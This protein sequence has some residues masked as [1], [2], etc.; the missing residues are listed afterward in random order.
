MKA[1]KNALTK[2]PSSLKTQYK[3]LYNN[4]CDH[5]HNHDFNHPEKTQCK[6]DLNHH[7]NSPGNPPLQTPQQILRFILLYRLNVKIILMA[8][9]FLVAFLGLLAPLLQKMFIDLLTKS[10][11]FTHYDLTHIQS[12]PLWVWLLSSAFCLIL[13]LSCY[14]LLLYFSAQEAIKTQKALSQSL[15]EHLLSLRPLD[16]QNKSTGDFISAYSTDIPSATIL[17]E[18]SLPQGLNILFPLILAPFVLMTFFHVPAGNLIPFLLGF[19]LL[20]MVLAYRQSLFFYKFKHLAANRISLVHEWIQNMKALRILGWIPFFENSIQKARIVETSN[21][22]RMLNNGQTMNAFSSSMTFA[23]TAYIL[24]S[25]SSPSS[26]VNSAVTA[27][28]PG[29]LLAIFWIV[30]VFLTRSF[31]QLPW[32]LTFLFDAWTSIKRLS[33]IFALNPNKTVSSVERKTSSLERKTFFSEKNHNLTLTTEP[34]LKVKGLNLLIKGNPILKN[35]SFQTDP[36][37][38]VGLIGPVGSGK[39][40]LLLSLMGET[41]AT[42]DSYFLG[43]IDML[44][45]ERKQW[46]EFFSFIPQEGFLISASVRD[47][48][49]FEYESNPKKDSQ[50]LEVLPKVQF[51][52]EKEGLSQ[53]LDTVIGERGLNLSGGQKQRLSLA[54]TQLR[55]TPVSLFDDCLSAIDIH[56]EDHIIHHLFEKDQISRL[57]LLVTARYSVLKKV[58]RILFLDEGSLLGFD[59]W[60]QLYSHSPAFYHFINTLHKTKETL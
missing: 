52:L 10:S 50:I 17:V 4:L 12:I 13:S 24:W 20:N 56:T 57:R 25:L 7:F 31:R 3:N 9:A 36:A 15:Y 35:I 2:I 47:N 37:E 33:E 49:H 32:F 6:N 38:F 53:G 39:S 19:V 27:F 46:K 48:L 22:I 40:L 55:Q 59:T 45:I 21:R 58:H 34:F 16:Y 5:S 42:F 30:S 44:K 51:S 54:R 14:Q 8:L 26:T 1:F 29:N 23:L 60:D 41:D 43:N 18:Q 28:S 11:S